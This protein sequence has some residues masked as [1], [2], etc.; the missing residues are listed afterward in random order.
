MSKENMA[1][2]KVSF[3]QRIGFKII[4]LAVILTVLSAGIVLVTSTYISKKTLVESTKNDMKTIAEAYGQYVTTGFMLVQNGMY[5]LDYVLNTCLKDCSV[6]GLETSYGYIVSAD[7][8]M[9]YHPNADKIGQPV[10]NS[11]V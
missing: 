11:V 10:E 2:E 1:T 6:E 4:L 7:G 3:H 9:L 5:E 8:T